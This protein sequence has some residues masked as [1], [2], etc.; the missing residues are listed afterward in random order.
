MISV[1]PFPGTDEERQ[2]LMA[3]AAGNCSCVVDANGVRQSTCSVHTWWLAPAGLEHLIWARRQA[4][5][6][7]LAEFMV[8]HPPMLGGTF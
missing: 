8:D 5:R 6:W 3:A 4:A 7:L 1:R 2:A